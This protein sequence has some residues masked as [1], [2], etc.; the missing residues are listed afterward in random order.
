MNILSLSTLLL[1]S[2]ANP[3]ASFR[4]VREV[5]SPRQGRGL[6]PKGRTSGS[7]RPPTPLSPS[8]P[9]CQSHSVPACANK[10]LV[11]RCSP[12]CQCHSALPAPHVHAASPIIAA[13]LPHLNNVKHTRIKE[14]VERGGKE[15]EK[16]SNKASEQ[17]E[18][19]R[20]EN[21]GG[22]RSQ[23]GTERRVLQVNPASQ[24]HL[25]WCGFCLCPS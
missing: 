10:H 23:E 25:A 11:Q 22:E 15:G 19:R 5:V 14:D 18:G 13:L 4:A 1:L 8:G 12:A 16:N 9:A 3:G 17:G 20:K 6:P 21:K 24:L 7:P 2:V